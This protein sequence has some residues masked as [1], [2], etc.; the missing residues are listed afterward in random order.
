MV[1][2]PCPCPSFGLQPINDLASSPDGLV[3]ATASEDGTVR[4]WD[5]KDTSGRCAV[6]AFLTMHFSTL[7]EH[8]VVFPKSRRDCDSSWESELKELSNDTKNV[9]IGYIR[10]ELAIFG[11]CAIY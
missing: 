1:T 7:R 9:Q 4:F 11:P 2:R 8:L 5:T 6:L 3:L 10:R